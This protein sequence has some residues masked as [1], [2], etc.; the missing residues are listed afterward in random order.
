MTLNKADLI[1]KVLYFFCAAQFLATLI[2]VQFYCPAK[3]Q[4]HVALVGL[5]ASIGI[6]LSGVIRRAY[7][8]IKKFYDKKS[9]YRN[10]ETTLKDIREKNTKQGISE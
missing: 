4:F 10:L 8:D 9:A 6:L 3:T 7:A 1:I 5:S 2:Y